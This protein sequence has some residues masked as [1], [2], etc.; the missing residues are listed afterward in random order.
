MGWGDRQG[1]GRGTDLFELGLSLRH[2]VV[3]VGE[4]CWELGLE[5]VGDN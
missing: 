5:F 1:K 4:S 2:G 3:C